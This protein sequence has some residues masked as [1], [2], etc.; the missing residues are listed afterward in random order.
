[1][2]MIKIETWGSFRPGKSEQFSASQHGHAHAVAKAIE[3]L[4]SEILPQAI[5]LD[6][7][8]H[9]DGEFPVKGFPS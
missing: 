6:H 8:C 9:R 7:A 4:S 2:G 5:A 3:F 1:M